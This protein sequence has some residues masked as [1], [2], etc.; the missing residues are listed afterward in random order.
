[1]CQMNCGKK[2]APNPAGMKCK[3]SNYINT[4]TEYKI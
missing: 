2:M 1:M 3:L 4:T